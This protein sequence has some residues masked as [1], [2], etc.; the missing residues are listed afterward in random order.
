MTR[1][2]EKAT[3]ATVLGSVL[4]AVDAAD[5]QI[6]VS[7]LGSPC[8]C[9]SMTLPAQGRR[10]CAPPRTE[11]I[12]AAGVFMGRD[13]QLVARLRAVHVV[14]ARRLKF[15]H[16]REVRQEVARIDSVL[17]RWFHSHSVHSR[18]IAAE[19]RFPNLSVVLL[20]LLVPGVVRCAVDVLNTR[21]DDDDG[22]H[23]GLNISAIAVGIVFVL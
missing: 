21:H 7:I 11:P 16:Q 2:G 23:A 3:S 8:V 9:S 6:L 19:L 13:W 10:V 15:K 17:G 5:P 4:A 20:L 22:G 1:K 18:D 14:L 12:L